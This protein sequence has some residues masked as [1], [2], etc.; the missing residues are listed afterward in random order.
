M[1][2]IK[3]KTGRADREKT[4]L[5]NAWCNN[6]GKTYLQD[7]ADVK[8][9]AIQHYNYHQTAGAASNTIS[10]ILILFYVF[11]CKTV[12][13][14]NFY[15]NL[16]AGLVII[17]ILNWF[18]RRFLYNEGKE[19]QMFDTLRLLHEQWKR[20]EELRYMGMDNEQFLIDTR[21]M[22][23]TAGK[24]RDQRWKKNLMEQL[25]ADH[26]ILTSFGLCDKDLQEY[27]PGSKTERTSLAD[28]SFG[29]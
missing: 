3:F 6:A 19:R 29:G 26:I 2:K 28:G 21:E 8:N 27:I 23:I 24:S 16:I 20:L 1:K 18:T 15:G 5:L 14:D 9:L 22:M 10:G 7:E 4:A 13:Y 12:F 11:I 25:T 17:I